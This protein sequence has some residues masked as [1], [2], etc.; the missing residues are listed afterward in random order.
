MGFL[1]VLLRELFRICKVPIDLHL[2]HRGKA[3]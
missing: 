2:S 1:G 3:G